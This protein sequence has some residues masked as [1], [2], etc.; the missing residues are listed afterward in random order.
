LRNIFIMG[1][2]LC[3]VTI[4]SACSSPPQSTAAF[5]QPTNTTTPTV[6]Q[7]GNSTVAPVTPESSVL[8]FGQL[9]SAGGNVFPSKCGGCHGSSG[10]GGRAASVIGT[11]SSLGKYNS[12]GQLLNYIS[13]TMPANSPGSL[14]HQ[15]YLKI[16][17]YLLVQNKFVSD[18]A[19]FDESQLGNISIKQ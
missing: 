5:T 17:A 12:A 13:L 10:Q 18:G 16:L 14:S 19:A 2:I 7:P 1:V 3:L 4:L 15:D 8:T 6:V 11:G 9:S